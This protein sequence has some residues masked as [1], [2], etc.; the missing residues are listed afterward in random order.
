MFG[1]THSDGIEMLP[2]ETVDFD[3]FVAAGPAAALRLDL[4]WTGA[5]D[6]TVL[7]VEIAK[8]LT[9]VSEREQ[10]LGGLGMAAHPEDCQLVADGRTQTLTVLLRP[11]DARW[12]VE[13]CD[14][15]AGELAQSALPPAGN[16]CESLHETVRGLLPL[17]LGRSDGQPGGALMWIARRVA[18]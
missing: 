4:T 2:T 9:A 16:A 1:Q 11:C 7:A 8:L 5:V 10:A 13:R 6:S 12:S 17:T 18:A 14:R 3:E 15:L